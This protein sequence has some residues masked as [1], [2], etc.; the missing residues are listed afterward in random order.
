MK[1]KF[2]KSLFALTLAVLMALGS[3][4]QV[5]TDVSSEHFAY[6]K[7]NEFYEKGIINGYGDGTF[8]PDEDV[9]REEFAKLLIET[10]ASLPELEYTSSYSD[11]ENDRWSVG[12]IVAAENYFG[13]FKDAD[14]KK[15]FS[16][17]LFAEREDVVSAIVK[18]MGF[19]EAV[20]NDKDAAKSTFSDGNTISDELVSYISI[21]LEKGIID[22][23]DTFGAQNGLTRAQAVLLLDNALDIYENEALA[24]KDVF[25]Q[26][27]TYIPSSAYDTTVVANIGDYKV[28]LAEYRYYYMMYFLQFTETFGA[29]WIEYDA[30]TDLFNVYV[31]D[32]A[33]MGAAISRI[34]EETEIGFSQKEIQRMILESYLFFLDTF[35][36]DCEKVLSD[37]YYAT[38][39]FAIKNELL[40]DCYDKLIGTMYAKGTEKAEQVRQLAVSAYNEATYVRAKHILIT[41]EAREKSEAEAIATEILGKVK[42]GADFEQLTKQYNEDPGVEQFKNGYYF[43]KGEM[44][45][46]FENAVYSLNEGEITMVETDYGYHIVKRLPIDDDDIYSSEAFLSIAYEKFDKF[47]GDELSKLNVEYVEDFVNITA[48]VSEEAAKMLEQIK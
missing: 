18:T 17:H 15:T 24:W 8:R 31:T 42:A 27:D 29:E 30:Y 4:A 13:G 40:V 33:K 45:E 43:T 14:G 3:F 6:E 9:S 25:A 28:T 44:I 48:P 22:A 41:T 10:F 23:A 5:F 11:V 7:I 2:L 21:A 46:P 19:P 1:M 32:S 26:V 20:A 38:L 36:K 37:N 35:G 34:S 47:V 39:G 12:Y 16:P